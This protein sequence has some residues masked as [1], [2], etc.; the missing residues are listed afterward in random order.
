METQYSEINQNEI[1]S[2][3]KKHAR[4]VGKT[5]DILFVIALIVSFIFIGISVLLFCNNNIYKGDKEWVIKHDIV[6]TYGDFIGG[7]LGT[8]IALYSTYLLVKTLGNQLSV[9]GDVMDTN[10]NVI[11]TNNK[12][13][14]QSFLQIFDNKF[15]TLLGIYQQAKLNYKCEIPQVQKKFIENGGTQKEV[16]IHETIV[17]HGA[18]ALEYLADQFSNTKYTDKRTYLK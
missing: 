15:N 11:K 1:L 10:K 13:I 6:G 17:I 4:S 5:N 16:I 14:Y 3:N 9:N 12:T 2:E 8:I 7:V 18:E